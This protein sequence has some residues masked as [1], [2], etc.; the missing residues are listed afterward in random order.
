MGLEGTYSVSGGSVWHSDQLTT[1]RKPTPRTL[2]PLSQPS[3]EF[4]GNRRHAGQLSTYALSVVASSFVSKFGSHV[5]TFKNLLR[6]EVRTA[7][8]VA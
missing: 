4:G 8:L 1:H 2:H 6:N 3:R 5:K 7:S